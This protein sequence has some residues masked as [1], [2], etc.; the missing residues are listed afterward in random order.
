MPLQSRWSVLYERTWNSGTNAGLLDPPKQ[1]IFQRASFAL[2]SPGTCEWRE[3]STDSLFLITSV[4]SFLNDKGLLLTFLLILSVWNW[5]DKHKVLSEFREICVK[6]RRGKR[7]ASPHMRERSD[8]TSF[9]YS[10]NMKKWWVWPINTRTLFN[11]PYLW[12]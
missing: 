7:R 11:N 1:L 6:K 10:H 3:R 8:W 2:Q 12:H 4:V 9:C 5:R